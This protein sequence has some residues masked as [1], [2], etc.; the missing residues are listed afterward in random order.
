MLASERLIRAE[1]ELAHKPF[2]LVLREANRLYVSA[3]SGAADNLGLVPGMSLSDL[4]AAFPDILYLEA[5]PLGDAK[6]LQFLLRWA[7]R[8]T[9]RLVRGSAC[10]LFLDIAGASHLFGD[11]P[12]LLK[13]IQD[14]LTKLGFTARVGLAD[15]K[16]AAWGFAHYGPD[17]SNIGKENLRKAAGELPVEALQ[18][19]FG[20]TILCRQL[21][22]KTI[23]ALLALPRAT[24]ASRIGL[25]GIKRID[26]FL[27]RAVEVTKFA[28]HQQRL[29]E[30]MQF[31]D[32]IGHSVGVEMALETLLTRLCAR[33]LSTHKGIRKVHLT[34]ERV[35]HAA[36]SFS[37]QTIRP[38]CYIPALK[39]LFA[40]HLEQMDVGFGIERMVLHARH[41]APLSG[42]QMGLGN[43]QVDEQKDALNGLID[44]LS[45]MFGYERVQ[46]FSPADS[47]IPERA[48]SREYALYSSHRQ[49]WTVPLRKRPLRLFRKPVAVWLDK[50]SG[51]D[52][53]ESIIWQNQKCRL[54][55]LTG[56][57]RIEPDWWRDDPQW[58]SGT[59]DYWWVQTDTGALLWLYRVADP[60]RIQ[61]FVHGLGS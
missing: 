6:C 7:S 11:E 42:Q 41:T 19:G 47:H 13:T 28:R 24:L 56:P 29:V 16:A 35:D 25:D 4:Q 34:L 43:R 5:D 48:F 50:N 26:Q 51:M 52:V 23:H 9:P 17:R 39:R 22:L 57:E 15:T 30:E 40:R 44:T 55:P 27:G 54:T 21:G 37:I 10:D 2:A 60:A 45:N 36:L 20:P 1:P 33:L 18:M 8:F 12:A 38:T 61:W 59:R 53:P 58:H 31:P 49:S 3:L 14:R 32:P 46:Y